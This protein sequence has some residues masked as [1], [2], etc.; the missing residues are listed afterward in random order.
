M[1]RLASSVATLA[2]VAMGTLASAPAMAQSE[3]KNVDLLFNY[4]LPPNHTFYLGGLKP[5]ADD[6]E[7]LT[8]GRVT[9][10][11]TTA[12]LAPPQQQWGMIIDGIA[13]AALVVDPM[14]STRLQLPSI[15]GLPGMA[16][17]PRPAV[18]P[19]GAP[20]RSSLPRPTSSK[21]CTWSAISRTPA[22]AWWPT[23]WST[24]STPLT[25]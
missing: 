21:A 13:D 17:W 2:V 12:S 7:R 20:T 9:V 11:F 16:T 3:C 1:N 6:V 25:A 4:F 5:W 22:R 15:A 18:S 10:T 8:E 19:C 24:A 23:R 14:E